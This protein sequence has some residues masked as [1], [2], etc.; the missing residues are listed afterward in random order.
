MPADHEFPTSVW[1]VK[2]IHKELEF[3]KIRVYANDAYPCIGEGSFRLYQF[4][5][6]I[7]FAQ[8]YHNY[9]YMISAVKQ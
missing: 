7:E 4:V 6:N 9:Y 5:S 8:K 3:H 2:A 1:R